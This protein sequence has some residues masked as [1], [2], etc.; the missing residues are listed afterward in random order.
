M[1]L[2]YV[3]ELFEQ[4]RDPLKRQQFCFILARHVSYLEFALSML[5][6]FYCYLI[7]FVVMLRL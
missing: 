5:S 4:C 1:P 2:Q 3:K 6:E 7:F